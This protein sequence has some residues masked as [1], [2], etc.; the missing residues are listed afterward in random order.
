[1]TR[2][3]RLIRRE[4]RLKD[5][6]AAKARKLAQAQAQKRA[7]ERASR[8]KRRIIVGTMVDAAGLFVWDDPT[9]RGLF[10]ALALL[11][12][13]P[14]PVAVL[15]GLLSDGDGQPGRSVNGMAHAPQAAHGAAPDGAGGT[16]AR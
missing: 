3:E 9:L 15:E 13:T 16:V 1:M 4:E 2:Q 10:Q 7:A 11:H 12:E 5:E 8:T 14:D 6:L